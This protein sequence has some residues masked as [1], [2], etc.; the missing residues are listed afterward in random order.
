MEKKIIYQ[1]GYIHDVVPYRIFQKLINSLEIESIQQ[2]EDYSHNLAGNMKLEKK[3]TELLSPDF[4]EYLSSV[5]DEYCKHFK[6]SRIASDKLINNPKQYVFLDS[7]LNYQRKHE[8]NP[9]HD[10]GGTLSFVVWIKIPYELKDEVTHPNCMSSNSPSNSL[11]AFVGDKFIY[12]IGVS[13]NM[14]GH[15]IMFDSTLKHLVYPFFT[16]EEFRISLAGNLDV[17]IVA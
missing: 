10:H 8:F 16:S 13:K 11:F 12:Q 7:W 6:I 3:V 9:A 4:Y 1:E 15:I 2:K 17:V 5:A 14:E